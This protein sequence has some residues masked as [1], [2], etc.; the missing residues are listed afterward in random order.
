MKYK[1][2]T[3]I[4]GK[5]E[6]FGT[7]NQKGNNKMTF[8]ITMTQLE[9]LKQCIENGS[10]EGREFKDEKYYF[11]SCVEDEFKQDLKQS[12]KDELKQDSKALDDDIPF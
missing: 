9:K 5:W 8:S 6:K 10:I 11:L 1:L 7:F 3:K 12:I 4:N 2:T